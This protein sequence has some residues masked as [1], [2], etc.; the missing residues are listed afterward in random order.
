MPNYQPIYTTRTATLKDLMFFYEA[1]C[2]ITDSKP[3]ILEFNKQY[4]LKIKNKANIILVLEADKKVLIGFIV[5]EIRQNLSDAVPCAEL[6]ELY[7][8]NKYRKLNAADFIYNELEKKVAKEKIFQLKVNCNLNSTLNQHFYVKR[9]FK[10]FKKQYK[11]GP[12][13][14]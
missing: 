4:K 2:V 1:V 11:K 5:A 10:I 3:D 14:L 13:K 7:V 6:Q 8:S 12:I 9:G